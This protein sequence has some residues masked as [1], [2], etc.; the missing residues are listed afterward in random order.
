MQE[1]SD[2]ARDKASL[3]A[4]VVQFVRKSLCMPC[5]QIL[6]S[7]CAQTFALELYMWSGVVSC[8]VTG[9]SRA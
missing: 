4:I 7:G 2:G 5:L 8:V 1:A 6:Q 3:D 9:S